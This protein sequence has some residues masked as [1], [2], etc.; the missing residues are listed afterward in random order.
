MNESTKKISD[1]IGFGNVPDSYQMIMSL[2]EH[3][4][5]ALFMIA[6]LSYCIGA[7]FIFNGI[8]HLYKAGIRE[9]GDETPAKAL[10]IMG[11]GVCLVYLVSSLDTISITAFGDGANHVFSYNNS[12][13]YN[14]KINAAMEVI[15][16]FLYVVGVAAIIRGFMIF[17]SV[18]EGKTN[19]SMAKGWWHFIGGFAVMHLD[20]L[21]AVFKV[22]AGFGG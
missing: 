5:P 17:K 13:N 16:K 6:A 21:T 2:G 4:Q 14:Q 18:T 22:S 9:N 10:V 20:K 11:I 12:A 1:F 7:W 19:D 3:L 8:H 15:Y